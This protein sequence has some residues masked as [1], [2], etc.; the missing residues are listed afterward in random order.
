VRQNGQVSPLNVGAQFAGC[1]V[2][3]VI[4]RGGMGVVYRGTELSLERP[5]AIKLI[6]A[7][8]A[9]DDA[10]RR[11]FEREARL[12]A[13]IDHPNVIPVYAAGEQD[14]DLYLIMRYVDGTDL[15]R[16]LREGGPLAPAEAAR[17]TDQVARA[18]DAAHSRGLVHRDVKPANVLLAGDH[19]YLT[20][21]GITRLVDEHTRATDTG[22]W[23][24][25]VDFMAP[26]HLRGD[27]TD[28][29]ADVYSLGCVLYA[30][31]TGVAPFRRATLA[32]TITAHL[33]ERP[34]APS[35][36]RPDLP[37]GFDHVVGRALAKNPAH[38]YASAG[39]LG[40]AALDAAAGRPPRWGRAPRAATAPPEAPTRMLRGRAAAVV[41]PAAAAEFAVAGE[42]DA[43]AGP[44]AA[45]A[46]LRSRIAKIAASTRARAA[47]LEPT[48][49]AQLTAA[50]AA[51]DTRATR[52]A[53]T[54][55]TRPAG[56]RAT[57]PADTQATRPAETVA[58]RVVDPA[59]TRV[60]GADQVPTLR[61]R[62][63]PPLP[64]RRRGPVVVGAA[65]LAVL[66][67]A[68]A[69]ILALHTSKPKP[70]RPFSVGQVSA[71]VEQFASAYSARDPAALRRVLAPDVM[72]LD[73]SGVEHGAAAVLADYRSQF[74]TRPLPT[75]YSVAD[76]I[77]SGG[78]VGRASGTYRVALRGGTTLSGRVTFAIQRI[79]G[80]P[81]IGLIV[82]QAN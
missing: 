19:V 31:L 57:R 56:T 41:E 67:A 80:R 17:V 21:F 72:R 40:E 42:P 14:G 75:G 2:E 16:R 23:V 39:E 20:D 10:A 77:V 45:A 34:P 81:R 70:L 1:R 22:E 8:R 53:E 79:D 73:P 27:A 25:T 30:C 13:A 55:A 33:R 38:R 68:A 78:W 48:P 32:A 46:E 60:A 3:A 9:T 66:I 69:V 4:G 28:A 24:G 11:R 6:A 74:D 82:T 65:T 49:A 12:M 71:V 47:E 5:V 37:R 61:L 59:P 36:A 51:A 76:M 63:T 15:Q 62:D 64:H 50:T 43:A 29:R 35:L 52:R 44:A 7:D 58:T 18:L 54:Q 26:E